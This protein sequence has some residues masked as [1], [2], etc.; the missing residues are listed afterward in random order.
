[1]RLGCILRR[2]VSALIS[3]NFLLLFRI[4]DIPKEIVRLAHTLRLKGWRQ[5]SLE[6]G[7]DIDVERLSG[8]L[9]NAVYVVSPP[10]V[11]PQTPRDPQDSLTSIVFKKPPQ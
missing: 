8:A 2:S 9:T 5:I 1:M 10:A 4:A 7:G 3:I 6:N 11:L